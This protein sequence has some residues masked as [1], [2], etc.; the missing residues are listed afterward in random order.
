MRL[1][2]GYSDFKKII[3]ESRYFV[4]KSLLIKEIID[5]A[6]VVLVTR[7]RRFGKTLNLS[8]LRYFFSSH[9]TDAHAAHHLFENL[10]ITQHSDIFSQHQGQYVVIYLTFK[11][12]KDM[13]YDAA[14]QHMLELIREIYSAFSAELLT[15]DRLNDFQKNDIRD[16]LN[17]Q[18]SIVRLSMTLRILSQ[19]LHDHYGKKIC[20]LI[21]EYD[22]PIQCG[23][24]YGYYDA[25]IDFFRTFLGAALKD[26]PCLF[27]AVLTGILRVSKESVFSGLNNIK[28]YSV[29]HQKYS[30]YFGFTE[31]EVA[32]L[33]K[34]TKL[35]DNLPAVKDWYN[36]Y[37]IGNTVV[38]NPWSVLNYVDALGLLRPYWIN[39]SDNHLIKTLFVKSS[40]EVKEHFE[41]LL[42]GGMVERL[43]DDY[44]AFQN[45]NKSSHTALWSLFVMTGYLTVAS[46]SYT[47]QGLVCQL[48]IPNR[49]IRN[50]YRDIIEGWLS[51]DHGIE[52]YNQFIEHL[53]DGDMTAFE[54]DLKHILEQTVSYHDV[55]QE[56]EVFY[57]G[58]MLGI[59]ASLYGRPGYE[60]RSNRESGYGRYD[61][62]ILANNVD[63]PTIVFEFKI[64]K[65]SQ[66]V[67]ALKTSAKRAL[68]QIETQ[69]YFAEAQQ[70]NIKNIL[71]IGIAFSGKRFAIAYSPAVYVP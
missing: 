36:G 18:V 48:M 21:D 66:T 69:A 44:F 19:M 43:V 2:I 60:I 1:P 49:E 34:K 35:Y 51:S 58:F 9:L 29:L 67:A 6:E 31:V 30:D 38:Y 15:S 10:N 32:I 64:M 50:L 42:Q 68:D 14:Y 65:Q 70:R 39:T 54:S 20:I 40:R 33:L 37:R 53:L 55:G 59:T 8:M 7:P 11:D 28:V 16:I 13:T 23:Y 17:R 26:N 56:S 12:I 41:I 47:D 52:W 24:L 61:Y 27:K 5:D 62:M 63:K 71:K 57:H 4:D 3:D 25:M 46:S 22:T 45:L